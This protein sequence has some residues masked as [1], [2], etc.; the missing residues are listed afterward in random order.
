MNEIKKERKKERK[1]FIYLKEL[2]L[3]NFLFIR[4]LLPCQTRW[5]RA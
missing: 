5:G 3:D 4:N 2:V 1:K